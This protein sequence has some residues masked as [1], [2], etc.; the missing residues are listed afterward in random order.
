M[1]SFQILHHTDNDSNSR[2]FLL[3]AGV[4]LQ[5]A[6]ESGIVYYYDESILYERRRDWGVTLVECVL[7]LLMSKMWNQSFLIEIRLGEVVVA[8]A[9]QDRCLL[10]ARVG[11]IAVELVA[12]LNVRLNADYFS[13]LQE[14]ILSAGYR[15]HYSFRS[16][17]ILYSAKRIVVAGCD[18]QELVALE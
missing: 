9:P 4:E 6:A 17:Q 13:S 7:N 5:L 12:V 16:H 15:H 3:L 18:E 11:D 14:S 1:L 8:A 2:R 10:A